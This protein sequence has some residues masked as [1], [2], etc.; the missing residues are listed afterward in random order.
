MDLA[1]GGACVR[2]ASLV[3]A[4]DA[5]TLGLVFPTMWDPLPMPGKVVWVD[6][7][8]EGDVGRVGVVFEPTDA[9]VT[10]SLYGLLVD[11]ET[12]P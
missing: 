6:S 12:D 4:G 8:A 10:L 1:L 3:R 7:D 5:V 9:R 11:L 2:T